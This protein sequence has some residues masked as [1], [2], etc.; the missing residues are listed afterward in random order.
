M[1]HEKSKKGGLSGN[2]IPDSPQATAAVALL[3]GV[4]K[5]LIA[6]VGD[7]NRSRARGS[8]RDATIT[9]VGNC[10]G[11]SGRAV[12]RHHTVASVGGGKRPTRV[13]DVDRSRSGFSSRNMT[14][15]VFDVDVAVARYRDHV[16]RC[17]A[18]HRNAGH[19]RIDWG[20]FR[21]HAVGVDDGVHHRD[22][23]EET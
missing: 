5:V 19:Y 11:A 6:G 17:A 13:D 12:D 16:G 8:H 3:V 20:H 9:R 15:V 2:Y 21:R 14:T 7:G 23:G 1:P 22:R 4:R 18:S 10:D